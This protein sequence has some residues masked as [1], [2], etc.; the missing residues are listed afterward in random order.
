MSE[1]IIKVLDALAE[2]FGLVIDWT[3]VNVIPYIKELCIKC[4]N[5]EIATSTIWMLFGIGFLIMGGI[6]FKK[7]KYYHEKSD[8][9]N[10]DNQASDDVEMIGM[11]FRISIIVG[12][13][14][15]ICQLFDIVTCFIIPEKII[16]EQLKLLY[17]MI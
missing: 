6:L 10:K 17:K 7:K 16:I 11:G 15:T 8:C 2:K 14:I 13:I 3:A 1:E 9:D 5:Y 12:L 4:V